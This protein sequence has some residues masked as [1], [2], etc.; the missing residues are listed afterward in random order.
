MYINITAI[1]S[2][3]VYFVEATPGYNQGSAMYP[4]IKPQEA[5][6][7][8]DIKF[9]DKTSFYKEFATEGEADAFASKITAGFIKLS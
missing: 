9:L 7:K 6:W 8:V 4:S 2:V 1:K 5:F 3:E